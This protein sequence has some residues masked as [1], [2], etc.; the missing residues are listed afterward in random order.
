MMKTK[1]ESILIRPADTAGDLAAARQ[2]FL[3]YH[4]FLGEDLCFQSFDAELAGLPGKYAAPEG[5]LL[6]AWQGTQAVGCVA[7]RPLQ[8]GIAEMKRLYVLPG[9]QGN[10]LGRQLAM[11]V[12]AAARR[13]GY[14]YMVLDTLERLTPALRLYQSLGFT[15]APAYYSNPLPGVVYLQLAL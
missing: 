5:C 10:G 11:A 2:L 7:M 8:P 12:I 3:A 15:S 9:A 1:R 4:Q 14:Q 13:A 6:L